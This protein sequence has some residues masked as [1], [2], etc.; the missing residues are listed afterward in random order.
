MHLFRFIREHSFAMTITVLAIVDTLLLWAYFW[1]KNRG[2][3]I[4]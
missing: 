1:E 2:F 4:P 3:L